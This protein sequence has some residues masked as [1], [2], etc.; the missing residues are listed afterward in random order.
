LRPQRL[1]RGAAFGGFRHP[2][3][4]AMGA[5]FEP[6]GETLAG[7]GGSLRCGDGAEIE[8]ELGGAAAQRLLEAQKSSSA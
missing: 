2:L 6:L 4:I 8:A 7:L 1:R 3:H 5:G